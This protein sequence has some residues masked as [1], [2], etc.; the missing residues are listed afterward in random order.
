MLWFQDSGFPAL[1]LTFAFMVLCLRA[2]SF[3]DGLGLQV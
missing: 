2:E 3:E 1:G